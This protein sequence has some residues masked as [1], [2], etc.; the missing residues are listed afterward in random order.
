MMGSIWLA[1]V[2]YALVFVISMLVAVLIK[3]LMATLG[4]FEKPQATPDVEA[5]SQIAPEPAVS[6]IPAIAAAVYAMLGMHK[7]V[8]IEAT[9]RGRSWTGEGRII[10]QTSHAVPHKP[11]R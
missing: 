6:D 7:I 9:G 5:G 10:H 11:K 8:H 1:L 3:G 4:L 2:S